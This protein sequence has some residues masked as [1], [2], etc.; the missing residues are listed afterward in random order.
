MAGRTRSFAH[1]DEIAAGVLEGYTFQRIGEGLGYSK[2]VV[3]RRLDA[4][5]AWLAEHTR[6]GIWL[7]R[8]ERTNV[9]VARFWLETDARPTADDAQSGS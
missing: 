2:M 1:A 5:R 8:T 7:N 9:Q 4:V 3:S 6:D